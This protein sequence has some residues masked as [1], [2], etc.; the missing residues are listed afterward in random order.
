MLKL[1]QKSRV[2]VGKQTQVDAT[3]KKDGDKKNKKALAGFSNAFKK[4]NNM[5]RKQAY[6]WGAVA[7]VALVGL[8]LLFSAAGDDPEDFSDFET[9]GYDLAN[10]P[11]S[12]D[13]AEQYL[14]AA[15]Y[16]DMQDQPSAGLYSEEEKEARQA[17]DAA[18]ED[19]EDTRSSS[20]D[21]DRYGG[22]SSSSGYY[23]S[24]SG[25]GGGRR[26]PTVV[27]QLGKAERATAGGSAM[28]GRFGPS[29][30]FSNFRTQEKGYDKKPTQ[31]A[32]SGNARKALYQAAMGSR[33]AAGLKNDKMLNAK[34]AMM[35]GNVQGSYAFADENGAVNLGAAGGLGLE[36]DTNAPV[37]SADL[38]GVDDAL[39]DAADDASDDAKDDEDEWWQ[40]ML[41]D[42]AK[43][44]VTGLIDMGLGQAKDAINQA[45]ADAQAEAKLDIDAANATYAADAEGAAQHGYGITKGSA[46][47]GNLDEGAA[48]AIFKDSK[49]EGWDANST[50][51]TITKKDGT[52]I[53]STK[54]EDGTWS[55]FEYT[56]NPNNGSNQGP[57]TANG[58]E[59][60]HAKSQAKA[61]AGTTQTYAQYKTDYSTSYKGNSGTGSTGTHS[62]AAQISVNG[63]TV[64]GNLSGDGKT[65][66]A[67]NGTTWYHT[68]DGWTITKPN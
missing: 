24:G 57:Y 58:R 51:R 15:K 59:A 64:F 21:Y 5:D 67:D 3:A 44:L 31:T 22:G 50:T 2:K 33:A 65:F 12:T 30:D 37:S 35:G 63:A 53:Q 28:S 43:Q 16:P 41:Q 29:G 27:G 6:T 55:P 25:R 9:R 19:Y 13:E 46:V 34:K 17:E 56:N 36:L 52:Q 10:M 1:F 66:K 23:G 14:L 32:G 7:L 47:S 20:S 38:G 61:W 62:G 18:A 26:T 68:D 8:T 4:L 42:A 40:T 54:G 48:Q 45:R 39:Q 11:F 49:L 60:S